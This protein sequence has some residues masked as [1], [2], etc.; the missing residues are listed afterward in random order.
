[1]AFWDNFSQKA[2]ETAAKTMQKAKE[3]SEI[4][5]F[6]SMIFD[7]EAK[8]DKAYLEIGKLY[9]EKHAED[10]DE[11]FAEL[12]ASIAEAKENLKSY[13][14]QIEDIKGVAHCPKCGAEVPLGDAFC[15]S[16]GAAMPKE[17]A[18]VGEVV[19]EEETAQETEAKEEVVEEVK[20]EAASCS[21]CVKEAVEET[22]EEVKEEVKEEA[23]V[24]E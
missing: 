19:S 9:V 23:P 20:E 21:D 11:E 18:I 8:I 22:V 5:K 1:M 17:E 24:Q 7:E 16:C 15:G 2:S 14:H 12:I 4:A 3:L 13:Q 6:K 10:G